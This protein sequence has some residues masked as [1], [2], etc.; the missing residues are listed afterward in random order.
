MDKQKQARMVSAKLTLDYYRERLAEPELLKRAVPLDVEASASLLAVPAGKSRRGGDIEFPD[1]S[2]AE[3]TL[4][5][6]KGLEGF[7]NPR[8][9][10]EDEDYCLVRWGDPPPFNGCDYCDP[11]CAI[12]LGLHYGYK[13]EAI[14]DLVER[15]QRLVR[16]TGTRDQVVE[17]IKRSRG[18]K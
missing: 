13:D 9:D 11:M 8:I 10:D 12:A 15:Y 14:A 18:S 6:L 16:P 3:K 17:I 5:L 4:K 1:R 2:E 7:P